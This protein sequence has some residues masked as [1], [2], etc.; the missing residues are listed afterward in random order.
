MIVDINELVGIIQQVDDTQKLIS[1]SILKG[2][3]DKKHLY[4][5]RKFRKILRFLT[6]Y[7]F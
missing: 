6:N 3:G 2:K 5:F 7:K 4:M 1:T